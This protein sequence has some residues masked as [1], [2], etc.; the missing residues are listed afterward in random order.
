MLP[1]ASQLVADREAHRDALRRAGHD[2][3]PTWHGRTHTA[4]AVAALRPGRR[5]RRVTVAGRSGVARAHGSIRFLHLRDATGTI[6]VL[7]RRDR[8]GIT[9]DA[10]EAIDPGDVLAVSGTVTKTQTGEVTVEA[11]RWTLLTKAL[12]A[13]PEKRVGLVDAEGR[14]RRRELDLIANEDTR[15]VFV[16]RSTVIEALRALLA[17]EGYTEVE[18]PILQHLAGGAA[19]R[20]FR[21][22]H[23]ALNLDLF[24]RVAPELPLKRLIIGG[25][26]AIFEL[27]RVFRN[28]GIDRQHNPEFTLCELYRAYA[29][30][31]DLVPFT[32]RLI[33]RLARA[34]RGK[35]TVTYQGHTLAFRPPWRRVRFVD[36]VRRAT[37]INVLT[38]RSP[39]AYRAALKKLGAAPPAD[40][41][42]PNLIDELFTEGVRKK[43]RGPLHVLGAPVELVPLAKRDPKDHR[44]AQR[45]QVVAAGMELVNAYTEENDPVEQ[46]ARFHKQARLRG[47]TEIHPLDAEYLEALK[48]GLPPTAGWGLGVDRLVMLLA[49]QPNI[50]DVIFF[51]LLRP[52][53][54]E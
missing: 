21:T 11:H 17:S 39:A 19:A 30:V 36:A 13:P 38:E 14:A 16:A 1:M 18:T 23:Q 9:Y 41:S 20:P 40:E 32:E 10:L 44:L 52:R 45:L 22:H 15:R 8:L 5:A 46:A 42:L 28:E 54:S 33:A 48:V 4:A 31:E 50:R 37:G 12:T 49:D 2:P 26:E 47:H 3:Y 43:T 25:Y 6:Q 24:L 7:F 27:G 35:T 34:V 53:R 51:P 29:T